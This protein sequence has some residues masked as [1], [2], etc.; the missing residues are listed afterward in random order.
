MELLTHP[1][2]IGLGTGLILVLVIWING[3]L[4]RRSLVKELRSLKEHLHTQMGINARGNESTINELQELR[5]QTENLRVTNSTLKQKPGRAELQTLAVYDK[6][7]HIMFAKAPGFAPAWENVLK[8]A[9][10]DLKRAETGLIPLIRSVFRPSLS[11]SNRVLPRFGSETGGSD[12]DR[13]NS[14]SVDPN[15]SSDSGTNIAG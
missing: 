12:I 1:F 6:A 13:P 5:Q 11:K 3:I 8:E 4:K 9:N 15:R 10:E 7:L 2:S 14:G